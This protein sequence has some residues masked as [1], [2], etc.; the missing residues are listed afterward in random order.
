VNLRTTF[1][2]IVRRAGLAPWPRL[3]HS[4]RASRETELVQAHP[5]HVVT[6]WLGH[7]PKIAEKHYLMTTEADFQRAA[8]GAL[9][10]ADRVLQNRMQYPP[11]TPSNPG[12]TPRRP[13]RAEKTGRPQS[14]TVQRVAKPR[15]TVRYFLLG[16][17]ESRKRRGQDSNLRRTYKALIGLANRRFRPLS[18][19]SKCL[20]HND[21]WRVSFFSPALLT[22]LVTPDKL[23]GMENEP[24]RHPGLAATPDPLPK[25]AT[26][27]DSTTPATSGK[28]SRPEGFPLF[29]HATKR[30]AKKIRGKL[31]YFGPWSDPE[32]AL[33]RYLAEKPYLES[34]RT[35]RRST[36]DG[37]TVGEL[38]GR[39]L[40]AKSRALDAGEI[41]RR[42]YAEYRGTADHLLAAFG[43]ERLVDDLAAD[44][45]ADLRAGLVKRLG[46]VRLG[47]EITRIRTVFKWGFEAGLIDRPIRYGP[48]FRKPSAS[49]LRRHRAKN[50]ERMLEAAELR[51]LIDAAPQ[52]VKA[53]IL[54][55]V[56]CG[57]GNH[58]VATLPLESLDLDGGW[59]DFARPKTGIPRRCPLWPETVAALRDAVARRPAARHDAAKGLV[60]LTRRGRPWI[61]R[62]TANP[63]TVAAKAVM[64]AVGVH[65]PG[66]GFYTLRHVFRTIADGARDNV[67][68]DR[69]M[70]HSDPSMAGVYRE[71]IDDSRLAAVAQHVHD[72]LYADAGESGEH[73]N[74]G[75]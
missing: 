13:F 1:E 30:W 33:D 48:E 37:L 25:G 38:R 3:F 7:T 56:N 57:F 26:M 73:N 4:L 8:D 61:V 64:E 34:G 50:G 40:T 44:D 15:Q 75:N 52:P 51:K 63:V 49:V 36:G 42:T 19:L 71:R 39:F 43:A 2:K 67:A 18:H 74:A 10:S 5:L 66:L 21:L 58:D 46:P 17:V 28:P 11:A 62:D 9:Q 45:F 53:M 12:T 24:R 54:L 47:N 16:V 69:I 32:G 59:I 23:K 27:P 70:G 65:R 60:F 55:G 14:P 31:H 29:A 22:P 72:W 6:S 41:T 20:C 68:I 35:P